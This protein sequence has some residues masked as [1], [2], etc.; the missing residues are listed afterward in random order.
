MN[1]WQKPDTPSARIWVWISVLIPVALFLGLL[2]GPALGIAAWNQKR[3]VELAAWNDNVYRDSWLDSAQ[4]ALRADR[5]YLAGIQDRVLLRVL[6]DSVP[7]ENLADVLRREIQASGG[8][9][10]RMS[11][12]R[13]SIPHFSRHRIRMEIRGDFSAT[14]NWF[15]NL[16]TRHPEA[17]VEEALLRPE[18]RG[19][20]ETHLTLIFHSRRT[21]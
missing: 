4:E 5:D 10:L 1:R 8:D 12:S 3:R 21:P 16:E 11:P 9:V 17:Y 18:A 15:R 19:K 6:P 20:V 7:G 2:N 13:D 14:L